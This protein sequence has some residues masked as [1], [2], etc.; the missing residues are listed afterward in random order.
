MNR[1][2]YQTDPTNPGLYFGPFLITETSR[3][4]HIALERNPYWT[5]P[6]PAFDAITVRAIER[7][8]TLEANLLSG[9]IDMIAGDL[10]LNIDEALAFRKPHGE[11]YQ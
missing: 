6:A 1:T 10:G 3:G 5:G 4:S 2:L 7:T 8:T 11:G 9:N